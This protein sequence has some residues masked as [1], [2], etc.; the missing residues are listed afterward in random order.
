VAFSDAEKANNG[1][2]AEWRRKKVMTLF[3]RQ[4]ESACIQRV[5]RN[6][7]AIEIKPEPVAIEW[8]HGTIQK[9]TDLFTS[10][11]LAF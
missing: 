5:N 1:R 3:Q 2:S 10:H 8:H 11:H 7:T 9:L 4:M 6:P